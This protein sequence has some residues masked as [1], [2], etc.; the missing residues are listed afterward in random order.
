MKKYI[1]RKNFLHDLKKIIK[2]LSFASLFFLFV[3]SGYAQES[4]T[5]ENNNEVKA[6][7]V[8]LG[9][10][11]LKRQKQFPH[12]RVDV[13]ER[14]TLGKL[15]R[16]DSTRV[17]IIPNEGGSVTEIESTWITPDP[18][19]FI[20][21]WTGGLLDVNGDGLEDLI[22]RRSTGGT[23]CCYSYT[24]FSLEKPLKKLVHLDLEDCGESIQLKDLNGDQ[25]KEVITCDA[26]F[27]YIGDQPYSKSPFPPAVYELQGNQFK[28]VDKKYPKIFQDDILKQ[29]TNL[30]QGYDPA[31]VLQLV[32]DYLI[33]GNSNKAWQEFEMLYQE[34]DKEEVRL[35]IATKM[36]VSMPNISNS[37]SNTNSDW[38]APTTQNSPGTP[39]APQDS[40][41]SPASPDPKDPFLE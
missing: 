9:T 21:G 24:I 39:E 36:G 15:R 7:P 3:N 18:K 27:K 37:P 22:L 12:Y 16:I 32:I 23:H 11:E 14:W 25:K 38:N 40:N 6:E 29:R 30:Q 2:L 17:R 20:Q 31:P 19:E 28:K 10:W 33:L 35:E 34:D 26:K 4:T 41:N 5:L 8:K 1:K 13:L